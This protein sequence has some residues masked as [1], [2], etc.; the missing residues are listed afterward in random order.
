MVRSKNAY[1]YQIN[2]GNAILQPPPIS[3]SMSKWNSFLFFLFP[4]LHFIFCFSPYPFHFT[5]EQF[6][7]ATTLSAPRI[8]MN[9]NTFNL[10]IHQLKRECDSYK[11]RQQEIVSFD[12]VSSSFW[13]LFFAEQIKIILKLYLMNCLLY[14]TFVKRVLRPVK[15]SKQLDY[16]WIH[17]YRASLITH[18]KSLVTAV[19]V[20]HPTT[21]QY[22][23]RPIFLAIWMTAWTALVVWK[24]TFTKLIASHVL[25]SNVLINFWISIDSESGTMES[26]SANLDA[27]DD[28]VPSLQQVNKCWFR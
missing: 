15:I 18:D 26:M 14:F 10:S 16:K 6:Q 13:L 4:F 24:S 25:V 22:H 20:Y 17:S 8:E 19:L 21:I 27:T 1:V 23:I 2:R 11:Q 28:L 5:A 7:R 12:Q 3:H 9:P